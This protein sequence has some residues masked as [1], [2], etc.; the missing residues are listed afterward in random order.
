MYCAWRMPNDLV[1]RLA[2]TMHNVSMGYSKAMYDAEQGL[3]HLM[4]P[5]LEHGTAC[6]RS[7]QAVVNLC[8]VA[9]LRSTQLRGTRLRLPADPIRTGIEPDCSFHIGERAEQY[10]DLQAELGSKAGAAC[11]QFV[12]DHP[13]DIAVEVEATHI[14]QDKMR[15]YAALEV[16]EVWL[17][18]GAASTCGV[19]VTMRALQDGEYVQVEQSPA[20]GLTPAVVASLINFPDQF[21][22][23]YAD[24]VRAAAD[25]V[26][27]HVALVQQE[28]KPPGDDW[29]P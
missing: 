26:R 8:K 5:S 28:A 20:L 25:A 17:T 18:K 9:G 3:I 2:A 11:A 21:G 23:R 19:S 7:E 16:P 6:A 29:T 15:R 10:Q 4:A 1:E 22:R 13:P 14:D 24:A 12:L 27:H